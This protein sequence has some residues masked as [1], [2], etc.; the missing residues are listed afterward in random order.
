MHKEVSMDTG[1]SLK[2]IDKNTWCLTDCFQTYSYVLEGEEKA[3]L[4]D[5]GNG[6]GN[7]QHEVRKLTQKPLLVINTHGH[8]DHIGSNSLFGEVYLHPLDIP[9]AEEHSSNELKQ[10]LYA[11]AKE[12]GDDSVLPEVDRIVNT[13]S[14]CRYLPVNE[15]DTFELG[16]RTL[17]VY[18]IPGHTPGSICLMDRKNNMLF[19]GDMLVDRGILLHLNHSTSL[20]IFLCS[21]RRIKGIL[22]SDIQIYAGHHTMPIGTDI[23]DEYIECAEKIINGELEG[24]PNA[25]AVGE[26]VLYLYRRIALSLPAR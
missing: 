18:E 17:E 26:A 12:M 3:M 2:C 10:M 24:I 20:D 23:I 15:G 22:P 21:M 25:S 19:S 9:V 4:I 7:L 11:F 13:P 6:F 8:L 16:G 1:Y 14:T 5:T